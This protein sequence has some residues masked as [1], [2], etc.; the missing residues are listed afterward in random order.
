M[1]DYCD[2]PALVRLLIWTGVSHIDVSV[3][4][5]NDIGISHVKV[6]KITCNEIL[7]NY[8]DG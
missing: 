1:V 2:S 8:L 6:L 5:C 7:M 4:N 3:D